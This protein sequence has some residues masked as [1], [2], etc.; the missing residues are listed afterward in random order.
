VTVT[1]NPLPNV[2]AT[3]NPSFICVGSNSLLSATP[4]MA[5]YLWSPGGNT[6]PT[7]WVSP[8]TTT[9]YSVTVVDGNGCSNTDTAQVIVDPC[10]GI[11]EANSD[12]GFSITPNPSNGFIHLVFAKQ[13]GS[14]DC[15]SIYNPD[16]QLVYKE[17]ILKN[18]MMIDLSALPKGIYYFRLLSN[19][20][21]SVRKLILQ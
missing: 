20:Q 4:G 2:I 21:T 3:A 6:L 17:A 13:A 16:G 7:G 8:T 10:I 12:Q 14:N 9:I 18:S 15:I 19:K 1:V 5:S 11:S